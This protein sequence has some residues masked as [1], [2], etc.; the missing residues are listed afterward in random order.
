MRVQRGRSKS[1][2]R[3]TGEHGARP[4]DGALEL[5]SSSSV[6]MLRKAGS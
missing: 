2:A 3:E 6:P 5:V 4:S 1:R